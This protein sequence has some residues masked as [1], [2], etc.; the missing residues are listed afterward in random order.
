MYK[1]L[2]K[3]AE[4][5]L[6]RTNNEEYQK[7]YKYIRNLYEKSKI[8]NLSIESHKKIYPYMYKILQIMNRLSHHNLTILHDRR[9]PTQKPKIYAITHIG[10]CDIEM[11]SE[12]IKEHTYI[13]SGDFENL[14]STIS[15]TFLELNGI[16]YVNEYNKIDRED[17][18]EK[19]IQKLL[20]GG[21]LMYFP[22]GTWNLTPSTP[23]LKLFPGIIKIAIATGADIIPTAIEQYGKNFVVNF[24][25]NIAPY[26][27]YKSGL[28]IDKIKEYLRDAMATAKWEIYESVPGWKKDEI[29]DCFYEDFLTER[30]N[31]WKGFTIEEVLEKKYI[32]RGETNPEEVFS[33]LEH[34]NITKENAF[35]LRK[36]K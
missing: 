27:L 3:K 10:K 20:S 29:S 9:L 16:I 19:M 28:E 24:G 14:H 25:Q 31:E 34:I 22:E 36:G 1:K 21:N 12:A 23:V 26:N 35:L 8:A 13:L 7:Y 17:A 18:K 4:K 5:Q 33:H 32:E 15:G 2:S 6:Q 30:M 11:I